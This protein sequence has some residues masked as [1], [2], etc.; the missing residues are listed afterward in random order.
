MGFELFIALRYLKAK[1]RG[2]FAAVT[3]LIGIT[4]VA[5]GVAALITTLSVMNG[6]RSDIQ[7]KIIGAQAHLSVYGIAGERSLKT[8]S[9]ILHKD[10]DVVAIAPFVLGQ[11]ILSH[12]GRTMGIALK[13]LDPDLEFQVN[14][15]AQA[16]Q[17]GRWDEVKPGP[18]PGIVLGAELAEN[19]SAF[20][21]AEVVLV[22]PQSLATPLGMLPRMQ[23]FR[24]AGLIR[25]G[26]YEYDSL[27]AYTDLAS[28]G[29]FFGLESQATGLAVRL[30]DMALADAAAERLRA[31]LGLGYSVRTFRD[32]N[33]TLFAALK[34]EKGVMFIILILIVLVASL[35][36]AS[37]L[38]LLGIEKTKEIGVLKALGA[39]PRQIARI[40]AVEGLL[41]GGA[42]VAL[43]VALGLGLC[44]VIA[45]Y[46]IVE[47]PAD[48]YYLSRVPVALE[49]TDVIW[50]S[51]SALGLSGAAT[52]YPA[53]RAAAVNPVEALRYG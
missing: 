21:G 42:G 38:I 51:L 27:T 1:R 33:R 37:T 14:D 4:G 47:L 45:K 53:F 46:P 48:I 40:F 7:K 24:V 44:A 25:T 20:P 6:F 26:Y 3:T 10:P 34:L 11:A 2:L 29:K 35:N 17:E 22:S 31:D 8:A 49:W 12:R 28:A 43:G 23:K 13:G 15:L 36:I 32:M 30:K 50:V 41:I 52:L 5:L 19:V 18:L 39:T 9:E 16:L